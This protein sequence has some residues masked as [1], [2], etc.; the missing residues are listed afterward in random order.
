MTIEL[1]PSQTR[2]L[3]QL[4]KSGAYSSHAQ[5]L[6][7]GLRLV[8]ARQ[9]DRDII[10]ARIRQEILAGIK[11]VRAGRVVPFDDALVADIKAKGRQRVANGK[12]PRRAN[13][14]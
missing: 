8:Q 6:A 13:N 3:N 2:T 14:A 12:H 4:L 10:R 11:Q 9:A 1:L 7:E 5:I